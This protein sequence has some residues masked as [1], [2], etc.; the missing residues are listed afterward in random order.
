MIVWSIMSWS[1]YEP[2]SCV[3]N[4]RERCLGLGQMDSFGHLAVAQNPTFHAGF[5][6]INQRQRHGGKHELE[7]M[8]TRWGTV[9]P[10]WSPLPYQEE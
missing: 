6:A 1:V 5:Y 7:Y 10:C 8:N 9:G 2:E 4:N 3:K